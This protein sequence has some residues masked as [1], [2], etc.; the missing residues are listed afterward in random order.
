MKIILASASPRRKE[1]LEQIGVT[2]HIVASQVEENYTSIEP[3]G[4]VQELALLKATA[5]AQTQ[6]KGTL[7]IG[8]DTI[9]VGN[10][11]ILGKPQDKEDAIAMLLLLQGTSHMV[12][13]GIALIACN[14]VEELEI[15]TH[16]VGTKV[17][18]APMTLDEIQEYVATGDPMDKAGAYGIQGRFAAFIE[19]IEGDYY[20][21]VGLPIA[22]LYQELKKRIV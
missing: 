20:N 4:I 22:Y 5:V 9:V 13:T 7:V 19:K 18:V 3:E 2:F 14:G 11:K 15:T 16:T 1:L 10:G 17:F 8:A 12:Y 6:T 21:V